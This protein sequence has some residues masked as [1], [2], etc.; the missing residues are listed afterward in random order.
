MLKGQGITSMYDVRGGKDDVNL[1]SLR[2]SGDI[3][4]WVKG[5]YEKD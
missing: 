3:D 1:A 4:I 5:G 2:Q